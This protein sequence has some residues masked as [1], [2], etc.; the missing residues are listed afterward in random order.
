MSSPPPKMNNNMASPRARAYPLKA[1]NTFPTKVVP[2]K[3]KKKKGQKRDMF[4]Y[5]SST[6]DLSSIR[7]V[8]LEESVASLGMQNS[9]VGSK[10]KSMLQVF[11]I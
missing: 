5:D 6:E 1:M 8:Y 3:S 7:S 9:V 11:S 10:V 2:K 4:L